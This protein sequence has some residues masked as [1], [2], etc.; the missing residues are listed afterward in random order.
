MI[1]LLLKAARKRA[2][3]GIKTLGQLQE[4][5]QIAVKLEQS[6]IPP[7][8]TAL[9]S[10]KDGHNAESALLIRSVVMEEML[11]IVLAANV[12]KAIGGTVELR[13]DKD[14][15][16]PVTL[17]DSDGILKIPLAKFS[18]DTLETFMRIEQPEKRGAPPQAHGYNTIAQFYAA[19]EE[20]LKTVCAGNRNFVENAPQV[21]PRQYYGATGIPIPVKDLD[22][23]L[24]ALREIVR[25]GEGAADTLYTSKRRTHLRKDGF[26]LA[27]YYRFKEIY[28][29]RRYT[30]TD[31]EKKMRDPK[32]TGPKLAV[33]WDAV[34]DVVPN[35]KASHFR[36]GSEARQ[37]MDDF[38][39][40]YATLLQKLQES[41]NNAPQDVHHCIGNMYELKYKAVELMKISYT[42]VRES[43]TRGAP[44]N[45]MLGPS[46]EYAAPAGSAASGA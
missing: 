21:W 29:E 3:E 30:A 6:T 9:Y 26:E 41:L 46:F 25:Q 14:T 10:I 4:H 2:P 11:H 45:G 27:H 36:P 7:Y 42:D 39:R 40:A 15:K 33:D 38:N 43:L 13:V 16:Y 32:P 31:A 44:K 18:K 12:L 8:L 20:G 17:P 37:K 23:A 22:S 35:P 1:D 34:H 24:T 5:L 19:I 28:C